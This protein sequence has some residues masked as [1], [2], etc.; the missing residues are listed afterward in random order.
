MA[1]GV[2]AEISAAGSVISHHILEKTKHGEKRRKTRRE[3][4]L[5]IPSLST[6]I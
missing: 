3:M 1:A 6:R 2:G 5:L 4:R